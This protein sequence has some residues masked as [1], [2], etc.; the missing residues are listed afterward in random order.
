MF[1]NYFFCGNG[2]YTAAIYK[3]ASSIRA[4]DFSKE[5]V[6]ETSKKF[7][8]DDKICVEQADCHKTDYQDESFDTI[9]MANIIHVIDEPGN[10]L[11]ESYRLIKP[12]GTLLLT[13]FATD[14]MNI[15]SKL[16]L[17]KNVRPPLF[18]PL[19]NFRIQSPI[20]G[21]AVQAAHRSINSPVPG[22]HTAKQNS[23]AFGTESSFMLSAGHRLSGYREQLRKFLL[24]V[25]NCDPESFVIFWRDGHCYLFSDR[26][27]QD[28]SPPLMYEVFKS[29]QA[30]PAG[31]APAFLIG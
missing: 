3:E 19:T 27:H 4:T 20:R 7:K 29:E 25:V 10:V 12:E 5:M 11:K 23:G 30:H 6:E 31:L 9:L 16:G 26:L 22:I 8:N 24:L 13:C 17:L 2:A 28:L 21:V 18:N 14:G 1:L 15:F